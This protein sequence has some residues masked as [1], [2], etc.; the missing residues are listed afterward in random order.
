M[1]QPSQPFRER[2]EE[3]EERTL[4]PLAQKSKK[5]RGRSRAESS[6]PVRTVF[7]QDR[8]RILHCKA[9]RRLARKTQVF[10]N[11]QGDHY[12]TRITHT[13]EVAQIGRTIAKA[14]LLN[15]DLTEAV[16]LGHDLGHT[17]F[18]HAGEAVLRK[19]SRTGFKHS[20]QSLRVVDLLE[21]RGQGLNLTE[22]VRD[23]I[24]RHS[25][26]KG[27][28]LPCSE[29][30]SGASSAFTPL[31]PATLEGQVVRIADII[32]YA[33]HDLDDA[34]RGQVLSP[35]DLPHGIVEVLGERSS[36]RIAFLV[37]DILSYTDLDSL[38]M[39][40][41][42]PMALNALSSLRDFLWENLYEN[43]VVHGQFSKARNIMEVLYDR[44]V[45][46]PEEFFDTCWPDCPEPLRSPVDRAVVD[47]LAGMTDPYV[48][49]LFEEIY[50]PQSWWVL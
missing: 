31:M 44:F 18:G 7:Q 47:F 12:R 25:K 43:P 28:I 14:L 16:A 23:G 49:R 46:R 40:R 10:L 22:E 42:S 30:E 9:F 17:P 3:I 41:M 26:G 8:D 19:L 45:N 32:A 20:E 34:I 48:I 15:E 37:E 11:P 33:N 36:D 6:C 5:S 13:L 39:V 21:R 27:M 35:G 29:Q 1:T 38:G 50:V 2:I 24:V 4:H